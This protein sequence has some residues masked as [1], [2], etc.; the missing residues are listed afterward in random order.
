MV[1]LSSD[2]YYL[3]FDSRSYKFLSD[4][5]AYINDALNLEIYSSL[6]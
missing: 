6:N 5:I 2:D 1:L 3:S 4:Y